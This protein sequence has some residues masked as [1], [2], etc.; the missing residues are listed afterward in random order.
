[1]TQFFDNALEPAGIRAPPFTFLISLA[2]VPAGT[3][4]EMAN[5]LVMDRTTLTRN[6][7]PL[8]KLGLIES[9]HARDKRSK[10]YAVTEQGRKIISQSI[11]LWKVAQHKIVFQLKEPRFNALLVELAAVTQIITDNHQ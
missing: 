9:K 6:L 4:T 8:E 1:V 7:K 10:A 5:N 11:P 3:L 2:S